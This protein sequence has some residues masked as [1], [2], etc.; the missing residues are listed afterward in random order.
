MVWSG[1]LSGEGR[2]QMRS[3]TGLKLNQCVVVFSLYPGEGWTGVALHSTTTADKLL[4]VVLTLP[5]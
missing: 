4:S 3:R 5:A 2:S 1:G